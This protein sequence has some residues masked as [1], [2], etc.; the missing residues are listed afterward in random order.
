MKKKV[1]LLGASIGGP[2]LIK[3]LICSIESLSSTIIIAQHMKEEVLPS[4]I[5]ELQ[6]SATV[7]V[8]ETPS[9]IDFGS[10]SVYIC[11]ESSIIVKVDQTY[12]LQTDKTNQQF[13]PDI[14]KLFNS[15]CAYR[16]E[17]EIVALIMTGMGSDGVKGARNLKKIGAKIIAQDEKS[18]PLYGMPKAAIEANVVDEVKSFHEIK[19]FFKGLA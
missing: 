5:R 19:E 4:F 12:R 2:T 7:H 6:E 17:F 1:V 10:P 13:T 16:Y 11:S 9:S 18:S 8:Y 14:N 3:T 15:F